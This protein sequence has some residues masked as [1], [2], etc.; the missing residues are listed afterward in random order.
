MLI[1]RD[2]RLAGEFFGC[3]S[4][5]CYQLTDGTRL[6]QQ[7]KTDEPLFLDRPCARL[8]FDE[9]REQVCLQVEGTSGMIP[10]VLDRRTCRNCSE[11]PWGSQVDV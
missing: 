8:F 2:A 6:W 4:G 5:R 3:A 9:D 7:V 10:V 11:P 1:I